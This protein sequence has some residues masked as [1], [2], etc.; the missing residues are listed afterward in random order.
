MPKKP[1]PQFIAP[2]TASVAKKPFNHPDWILDIGAF[3][4]GDEM[5]VPYPHLLLGC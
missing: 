5:P 4:K 1:P 3:E 2:M